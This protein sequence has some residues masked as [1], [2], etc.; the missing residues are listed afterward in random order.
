[1][2]NSVV[3]LLVLVTG[4]LAAWS[5]FV[6]IRRIEEMREV[7]RSIARFEKAFYRYQARQ[8]AKESESK[9]DLV[10]LIV[11]DETKNDDLPKFGDF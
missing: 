10:T 4:I 7:K 5:L 11:K 9:N 2:V 3:I 6:N 8:R 1:M